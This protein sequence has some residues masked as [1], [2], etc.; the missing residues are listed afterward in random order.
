M[1]LFAWLT[2][3]FLSAFQITRPAPQQRQRAEILIG[4]L[5]LGALLLGAGLLVGMLLWALNA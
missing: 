4:G 5:T 2:E 3:L 1:K